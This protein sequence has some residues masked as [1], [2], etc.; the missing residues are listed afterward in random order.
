MDTQPLFDSTEAVSDAKAL[1][2]A[3]SRDGYLFVKRLLPPRT[4]QQVGEEMGAVMADAGWIEPGVPLTRA[5]VNEAAR[6]VEPQPAFMEVFYKQLSHKSVHALKAHPALMKLLESL[7]GGDVLCVPHCV[8]RMA[9]PGMDDYAT[10]AHQDYVH[11][12]GSRNNWAAWIPFTPITQE[13]GGIAVAAGTHRGEPRDMRPSLGAG[14]MIIDE[15][16]SQLDWRWSPMDPGDVIIHNCLTI[17]RGLPNC[18]STMRVS[19][20]ARYQP[21][22]EPVGEKYL[23]V[24][25]QMKTWD[26]LYA[27]WEGDEYKYYWRDFRLDVVPF[28]YEWYDRRDEKAIAMG[29]A[30]DPEASV[31]LE[32][33]TLKHRDPAVRARAQRALEQL[34][35]S[36][37]SAS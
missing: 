24:S 4:V 13:T 36:R 29:E 37:Q 6:C 22:H 34:Q 21:I 25:H 5:A 26:D 15:D 7:F 3:A 2:T 14:Q 17:H 1:R 23:G 28:T 18:S 10:P 9:F 27:G 16:L 8:M 12:E 11:F 32:N 20:D 33:I 30:G 19:V 35:T 31:A